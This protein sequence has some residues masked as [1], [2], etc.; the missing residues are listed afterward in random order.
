[1][2][3]VVVKTKAQCCY[4]NKA[5]E[6]EKNVQCQERSDISQHVAVFVGPVSKQEKN[7]AASQPFIRSW[8]NF[9]LVCTFSHISQSRTSSLVK[10]VA[11]VVGGSHL[12][13]ALLHTRIWPC[14]ERVLQFLVFSGVLGSNF[15]R[16]HLRS[17]ATK[18]PVALTESRI[19][20]KKPTF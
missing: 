19:R 12:C 5:R 11:E 14:H 7:S 17:R 16:F 9:K 4:N 6:Q 1:M 2:S 13:S 20:R 8:K 18:K 3:T 10:E 15:D